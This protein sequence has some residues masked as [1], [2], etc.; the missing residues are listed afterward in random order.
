M[1]GLKTNIV[2]QDRLD[3]VAYHQVDVIR[4]TCVF[5]R[6]RQRTINIYCKRNGRSPLL[7]VPTGGDFGYL[8]TLPLGRSSHNIM[9]D[10]PLKC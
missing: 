5:L 1:C 2:M 3:T 9:T 7:P 10:K 6:G 4:C 8:E